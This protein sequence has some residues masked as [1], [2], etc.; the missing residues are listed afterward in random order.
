MSFLRCCL[1][2]VVLVVFLKSMNLR[3]ICTKSIWVPIFLLLKKGKVDKLSRYHWIPTQVFLIFIVHEDRR[4]TRYRISVAPRCWHLSPVH[5]P[6]VENK[7]IRKIHVHN[8]PNRFAADEEKCK[9]RI[10]LC[11]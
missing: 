8:N 6:P 9:Y 5:I 10:C 11:K 3:N 4:A 1:F 2:S 7:P